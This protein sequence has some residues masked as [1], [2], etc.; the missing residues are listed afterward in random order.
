MLGMLS[1]ARLAQS[2]DMEQ[3][4]TATYVPKRPPSAVLPGMIRIMPKKNPGEKT[5]CPSQAT[6]R[7]V[8]HLDPEVT[9]L[10]CVRCANLMV[11]VATTSQDH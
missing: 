9:N 4:I 3:T 10:F 2:I 7:I 5:D 8:S 6:S 1:G 11:C